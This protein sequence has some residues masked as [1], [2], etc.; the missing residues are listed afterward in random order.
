MTAERVWMTSK[1][2]VVSFT[3]ATTVE[4]TALV[5]AA[6][7]PG[8]GSVV[9]H[10]TARRH[11]ADLVAI[12]PSTN[13]AVSN[14]KRRGAGRRVDVA[15]RVDDRSGHRR[16]YTAIA[17]A[18]ALSA[19]VDPPCRHARR[20]CDER[21]AGDGHRRSADGAGG[22][23]RTVAVTERTGRSTSSRSGCQRLISVNSGRVAPSTGAGPMRAY[24]RLEYRRAMEIAVVVR[25]LR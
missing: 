18:S 21:F 2:V 16:S 17:D 24:V 19:A 3:I 14:S 20:Q 25:R 15:R 22:D 4:G 13:W 8:H 7:S 5:R 9:G 6:R 23:R 11:P 12:D 10:G 1:D